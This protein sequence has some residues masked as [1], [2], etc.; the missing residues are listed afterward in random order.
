MEIRAFQHGIHHL[1][2]LLT[3]VE[4]RG[5]CFTIN[6]DYTLNVETRE[7]IG[8]W[9]YVGEIPL[10]PS[11][12]HRLMSSL[13]HFA[14]ASCNK[15][16]ALLCFFPASS[17]SLGTGQGVLPTIGIHWLHEEQSRLPG[18]ASSVGW[19]GGSQ[20]SPTSGCKCWSGRC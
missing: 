17:C 9:N 10:C 4:C 7:T 19:D 5:F 20:A 1:I 3:S 11:P 18:S 2:K 6:Q 13:L 8:I 15:S 16:L 12:H 14:A